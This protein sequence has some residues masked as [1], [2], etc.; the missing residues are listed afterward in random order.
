MYDSAIQHEV[1]EEKYKHPHAQQRREKSSKPTRSQG[2][3]TNPRPHD[4]KE[5]LEED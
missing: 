4:D 5:I 3:A 1:H 2:S